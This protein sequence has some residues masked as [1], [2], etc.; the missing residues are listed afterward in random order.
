MVE[1]PSPKRRAAGSSPVSPATRI[2]RE[3]DQK[4]VAQQENAPNKPVHLIYLLGAVAMFY[5][6][7]WGIDW[8]WGLLRFLHRARF[9]IA[10]FRGRR[11]RCSSASSMYRSDRVYGLANEVASGAEEGHLA[12]RE[13]SS[14]GNHSRDR[15]GDRLGGDPRH[16]R[17]CMVEPHGVGLWRI[18][19]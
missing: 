19:R 1:H 13:G 14:L 3:R 18:T 12:D 5:V 17:L 8:I 16:L 15:D 11:G 7:Q 6:L 2:R 10:M 9:R 4:V